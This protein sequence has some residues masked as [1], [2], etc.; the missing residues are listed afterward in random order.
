MTIEAFRLRL[1]PYLLKPELSDEELLSME[2]RFS[3]I[4][5][6]MSNFCISNFESLSEVDKNR[7]ETLNQFYKLVGEISVHLHRFQTQFPTLFSGKNKSVMSRIANL[8]RKLISKLQELEGL[9]GK[10]SSVDLSTDVSF[11]N[12]VVDFL[13]MV[14]ANRRMFPLNFWREELAEEV[15]SSVQTLTNQ[16]D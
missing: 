1:P 16:D 12:D 3:V 9:V 4:A 7:I 14:I 2:L 8:M 15:V 6:V 11:S 13:N 10:K 5:S